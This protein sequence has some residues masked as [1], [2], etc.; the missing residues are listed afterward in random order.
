MSC[1]RGHHPLFQPEEIS[2]TDLESVRENLKD[3]HLRFLK[4][5]M[6]VFSLAE[7]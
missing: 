6:G 3:V 2:I 5:G 7:S 1:V 4:E